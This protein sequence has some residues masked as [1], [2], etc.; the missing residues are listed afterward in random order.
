MIKTDLIF[1]LFFQ[2]ILDESDNEE[3]NEEQHLNY[4]IREVKTL[5]CNI[6]TL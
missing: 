4:K 6:L 2:T 3:T 5:Y 1:T